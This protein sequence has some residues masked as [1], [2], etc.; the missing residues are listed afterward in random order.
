MKLRMKILTT[1]VIPAAI[2]LGIAVD[3]MQGALF[4]ERNRFHSIFHEVDVE[5]LWRWRPG[6]GRPSGLS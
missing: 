4:R 3:E 5:R 1:T 2:A 6:P